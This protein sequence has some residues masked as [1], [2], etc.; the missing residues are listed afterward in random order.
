MFTTT[1]LLPPLE[2]TIQHYI[3]VFQKVPF[4]RY[5]YN[6]TFLA[7]VGMLTNLFFGSLAGY[8]FAKLYFRCKRIIFIILLSSMMVPGI[9]T[10]VP[11][12]LVIRFFPLFGGNDI[13]G[14]G[15]RG[16]LNS[17]W[18][19][20]TP[21]AAGAFAVFFMRQFF[22]TLPNELGD[23]ARID[24]MREFNIYLQIYLPLTVP[25]LVTLGV[26]TF[27]TGWNNFLWPLIVLNREEL[28]T[29]QVG[30]SRFKF[31]HRSD[32]GPMM[33]GTVIATLPM[34]LLFLVAQKSYL[35]GIAF[36]GIKN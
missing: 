14:Q 12:F 36:S 30:L 4:M 35:R 25:A 34:I 19:I 3:D 24:G 17:Y 32:F 29:I 18:A 22:M 23:A 28:M 5:F 9:V 31:N 10:M 1:S 20:I 8:A 2:L 7:T 33:A 6:S 21:G 15:G 16:M 13:F 11:Q 27:H 26:M